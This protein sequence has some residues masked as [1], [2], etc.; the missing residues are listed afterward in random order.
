MGIFM[1]GAK[2]QVYYCYFGHFVVNTQNIL[3]GDAT[4]NEI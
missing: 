1:N 2:K 4:G 3:R